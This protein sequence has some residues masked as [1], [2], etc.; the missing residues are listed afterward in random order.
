MYIGD[1][2]DRDCWRESLDN[3]PTLESPIAQTTHRLHLPRLASS[4]F[5]SI[6]PPVRSSFGRNSVTGPVVAAACMIP[7]DVNIL[8]I[9]DSKKVCVPTTLIHKVDRLGEKFRV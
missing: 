2:F 8:D 3:A 4:L 1:L 9:Q 6:P 7:P 5:F